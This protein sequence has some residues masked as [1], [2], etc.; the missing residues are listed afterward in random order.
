[1]GTNLA[2]RRRPRIATSAQTPYRLPNRRV[3]GWLQC[4]VGRVAVILAYTK[5]VRDDR[6]PPRRR[7]S[8][9]GPTAL[10]ESTPRL[11]CLIIDD[12]PQFLDAA[13]RLLQQQGM[14]VV[15]VG[16]SSADALRLGDQFRPDVTLIDI[17][18]GSED[19]IALARRLA[20]LEDA[21]AGR[22]ILIST[23]AEDE[24]VELI[25]AS[26]VIGFVSKSAL[27]AHAIRA[28]IDASGA[29]SR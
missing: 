16:A 10:L 15:G 11:R 14:T 2:A 24:F 27:S 20:K 19:G 6:D 12:S 5:T 3:S 1:V 8:S 4:G 17:D 29:E 25:E 23:H 22:L 18:L 7:R 26:P 28:L 13:R 21:P 9:N